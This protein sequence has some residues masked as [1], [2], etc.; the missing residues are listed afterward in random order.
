MNR[1]LLF[2]FQISTRFLRALACPPNKKLF[3]G[4]RGV[5]A[6]QL[7]SIRAF[8]HPAIGAAE[9]PD[10]HHKVTKARSPAL[11]FRFPESRLRGREHFS[12]AESTKREIPPFVVLKAGRHKGKAL[13]FILL[14]AC[15]PKC[16]VSARRR[17]ALSLCVLVVQLFGRVSRILHRRTD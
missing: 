9:N 5:F 1:Q 14:R 6:V 8:Q 13:V 7:S 16:G 4:R 2:F 17:V 10:F 11:R 12:R 3:F 15:T